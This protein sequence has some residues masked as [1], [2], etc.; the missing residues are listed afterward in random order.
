[1]A[2]TFV[3]SV[4][5]S[6]TN[7]GN[8]T[9][10]LPSSIMVIND[11]VVVS[12]GVP[13]TGVS[14]GTQSSFGYTELIQFNSSGSYRFV[15]DRKI[16]GNPVDTQ[17]VCLGTAASSDGISY[18]AQILR[19]VDRITPE[20]ATITSTSGTGTTPDSPSITTVTDGA[21]VLSC[22]GSNVSDITVTAPSGY[23]NQVDVNAND[24]RNSTVGMATILK[25]S[26]GAE[27]PPS[28]TGFTTGVWCSASVALRPETTWVPD[29]QE[30]ASYNGSCIEVTGY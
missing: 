4:E 30:N 1:M 19:G 3:A 10:T 25:S 13:Q 29:R 21:F 8:V 6:A 22:V 18:V 5:G 24:T 28:W 14:V 17:V 12:G 15:V 16:M 9:L 2:I 20:D 27:D 26:N 11:V 7:G 23:S